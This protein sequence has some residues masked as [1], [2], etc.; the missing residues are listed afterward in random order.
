MIVDIQN[1]HSALETN[2]F[3][4]AQTSTSTQTSHACI[5]ENIFEIY[6]WSSFILDRI[7]HL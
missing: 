7:D 4:F 1:F 2:T 3:C 6:N 5:R